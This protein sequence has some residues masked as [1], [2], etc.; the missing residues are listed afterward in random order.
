M[1]TTSAQTPADT[2]TTTATPA[3]TP[4]VTEVPGDP[5]TASENIRDAVGA[6]SQTFG[7]VVDTMDAM[8]IEVGT[9][10]IS[11]WDGLVMIG[12]IFF[13]IALAWFGSRLSAKLIRRM[14]RLD[15]TQ[16]LLIEKI[17]TIAI[18]GAAFFLGIDLLGIDLT[19]LAVFS[20][21][22][23]LAIGF[24]LQKT[25]GNLIA[26]II[27][28]MDKSIK[29]GD[30]IAVADQAGVS[31][32]G[33]IRKIGIR[34]VSITTRDQKEYLIPNENLMINQVENWSYSSKNVRIQV[35]VG[36]SYNCD[37]K[38]A[39][40]LM[41]EAAKASKR[42]LASPPPTVWLDQY[43]ASSVDFII[44]CWISDPEEGVGNIRSEVLKR[45]WDLFQEAGIEIPY[46]QHDIHLRSSAQ[47]DQLVAAIAQRL[48]DKPKG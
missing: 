31:T 21:A 36:V 14:N 37:I 38:I 41:L 43:G 47:L 30:V 1:T 13:V 45:L 12:I 35:P 11:A 17:V 34:A 4:T 48:E 27:L 25:F 32:F 3:A 16:S 28:L 44:H 29:P 18:W 2:P 39:E 40:K 24:G 8:A 42:V 22:F 6:K 26:G 46:P 20:G 33:Q 9:M 7:S 19:A 15:Q 5:V 10:R 23:G